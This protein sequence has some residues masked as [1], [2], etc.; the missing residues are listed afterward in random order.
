MGAKLKPPKKSD[1]SEKNMTDMVRLAPSELVRSR[2]T[3][4]VE[5]RKAASR[6]YKGKWG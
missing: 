2:F 6:I 3:K 5:T 4:P 1:M